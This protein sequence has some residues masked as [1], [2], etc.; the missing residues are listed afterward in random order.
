MKSG[1]LLRAHQLEWLHAV[2]S[3]APLRPTVLALHHPPFST[4]IGHMDDIG[5]ENA[6][7]LEAVVR[8]H[9]QVELVTCGHLHRVIQKRFAGTFVS[10]C[11]SPAHQVALDLDERAASRFMMEPPGFQLHLWREGLGLVSHTASIG[12]FDGPYPFYEGGA[13]ID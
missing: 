2:L 8:L 1:G 7:G 5:L 11:P 6:D 9:P 4:G 13:L 12:R 3:G 10:T